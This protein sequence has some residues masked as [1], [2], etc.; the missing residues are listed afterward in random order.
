MNSS[1]RRLLV[2]AISLLVLAGAAASANAIGVT[3]Q[4]VI[5]EVDS[6]RATTGTL[7]VVEVVD[8]KSI[9]IVGP[10][11]ARVGRSGVS[12]AHREGD[13][14]TPLGRFRIT[15]AF[16]LSASRTSL[17][18]Y[19]KVRVGDCWI[20]VANDPKYNTWSRRGSCTSPNEN[21]SRIAKAG[22]YEYALTTAYNTNPVV[23]GKGSAIFVHVNANDGV[24]G[25]KPTSGCVSVARDVMKRLLVLLDPAKQP[26]LIV[27]VKR[28]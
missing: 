28:R 14:T 3:R 10:V 12:A 1:C 27:R 26:E 16:G 6:D 22:P 4:W 5:V 11:P 9:V 23:P 24:D 7:R 18:P 2:M 25:T 17:L 20:S 21:L 19:R 13:G 8:G 15:G